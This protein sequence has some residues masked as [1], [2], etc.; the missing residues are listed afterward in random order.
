MSHD[1][2]PS[3]LLLIPFDKASIREAERFLREVESRRK[4]WRN[5]MAKQ[6]ER[7]ICEASRRL[8]QRIDKAFDGV[9][10]Y[11]EVRVLLGGEAEDDYMSPDAQ[12]LLAPLEERDDWRDIPDDLLLACE[13]ALSYVGP[14]AYRFLIP[15]FMSAQL[16]HVPFDTF[17]AGS[18][19]KDLTV[20]RAQSME[21]NEE[22]RSCI[23][24][25]LSM[26]V[27]L[28]PWPDA[29]FFT[30]WEADDYK[31]NYAQT[32]KPYHYGEMLLRQFCER[33]G[34]EMPRLTDS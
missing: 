11:R 4:L 27:I 20:R 17:Y 1:K 8:L 7:E 9:T 2:Q 15:A 30:P 5:D 23:S 19:M 21:L 13:C 28:D 29:R 6:K 18:G 24:D 10:C 34:I 22:Q 25:Y 12:A 33:E 14:H 31:E 32:M 26:E 16:R 3:P